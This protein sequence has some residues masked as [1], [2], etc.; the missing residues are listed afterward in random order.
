MAPAIPANIDDVDDDWLSQA[1]GAAVSAVEMHQIG[2][3]VGMISSL[4]RATL[5]GDGPDS[6]V[7]KLPGLDEAARF[8]AEILRLNIREVGFYRELAADCPIRVP[9]AHFAAVDPDTHRFVLVL[10]DLGSCRGVDQLQ[11]MAPADAEQAVDELAG[12]HLRWWGRPGRS[13][14]GEPRCPSAIRCTRPFSRWS[15]PRAGRRS[16]PR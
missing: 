2:V 16:A 13:W 11:G 12:W 3:G 5:S 15:L 1:V 9:K 10:E 7:I 4:Y 14:S 8:T 6:V